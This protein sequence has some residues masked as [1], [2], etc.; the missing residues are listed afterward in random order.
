MEHS[1][2]I[3]IYLSTLII[4]YVYINGKHTFLSKPKRA[5]G[6]RRLISIEFSLTVRVFFGIKG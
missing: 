1:T 2:N 3:T 5:R 6:E 4:Y